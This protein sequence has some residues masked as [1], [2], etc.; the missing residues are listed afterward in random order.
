MAHAH[1]YLITLSN[2]KTEKEAF[3]LLLQ[4]REDLLIPD[5]K[6]KKRIL[7]ALAIEKRFQRTFD[8]VSIA[9]HRRGEA[10]VEL[11]DPTTITL[12]EIKST[13]ELL[14]NF[15]RGFFFGATENEFDLAKRLG[16]Q[17]RFCFVALHPQQPTDKRIAYFSLL[18]L[19][20]LI[21]TK[22]IQFQ[23]NL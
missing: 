14:P 17:F 2:N 5:S 1:S 18:Q 20:Q 6:G 8:L 16:E 3:N 21:R 22:R 11:L 15:P 19:E 10:Q 4:E 7:E 9:G 23:V 12:F 13:K